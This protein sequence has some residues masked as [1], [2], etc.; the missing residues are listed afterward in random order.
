MKKI[1]FSLLGIYDI[2]LAV[3][4]IYIGSMMVRSNNRMF[5]NYP[6]EWL[7]KTPFES[8]VI[9]RF[10][11]IILFG[12]GNIIASILCFMKRNSKLYMR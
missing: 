8:F 2:I 5:I 9:P 3:S 6:K 7:T 10:I 4:A 1:S 11:I 12:L